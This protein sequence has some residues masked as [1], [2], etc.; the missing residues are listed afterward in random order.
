MVINLRMDP[1]DIWE[2][3]KCRPFP[4][5]RD[6]D[7]FFDE[8]DNTE[9]LAFCNGTAD[10]IV[11]PL[12][13]E[14][15]LFALVNNC[16]EGVWGGTSEITRKAIRK[17]YPPSRAQQLRD[18]WTWTSEKDALQGLSKQRLLKEEQE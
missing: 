15:L 9:A 3:A 10:G 2:S 17:K 1:P 12:R 4:P 14:C 6:E 16:K 8:E 7:P 13:N 11:C 18:E 5:T